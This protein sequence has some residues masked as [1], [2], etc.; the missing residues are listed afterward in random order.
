MGIE[1]LLIRCF[2]FF[3]D[4]L[5]GGAVL[6]KEF[7]FLEPFVDPVGFYNFTRSDDQFVENGFSFVDV[8]VLVLIPGEGVGLD[9]SEFHLGKLFFFKVEPRFA[10]GLQQIFPEIVHLSHYTAFGL[11]LLFSHFP[12]T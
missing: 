10:L 5:L 12:V 1:G 3:S 7:D 4:F 6:K 2:Y 9:F 8:I 11:Q